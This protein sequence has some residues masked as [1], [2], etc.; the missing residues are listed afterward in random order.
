MTARRVSAYWK[1]DKREVGLTLF[2]SFSFFKINTNGIV[3][4]PSSLSVNL[5]IC[6]KSA[7]FSIQTTPDVCSL[8]IAMLSCLMNL[9]LSFCLF[10]V[11]LSTNAIKCYKKCICIKLTMSQFVI[12]KTK[13]LF[14]HSFAFLVLINKPFK[15]VISHQTLHS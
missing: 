1:E 3:T 13:N 6:G 2:G 7:N 12:I 5:P 9:G 11:F 10:P 14:L 4:V 15:L 8:A